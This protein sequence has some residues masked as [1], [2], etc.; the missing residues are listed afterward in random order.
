M[1][2]TTVGATRSNVDRAWLT[3][4]CESPRSSGVATVSAPSM[5]SGIKARAYTLGI[6]P[7]PWPS[8]RWIIRP[9]RKAAPSDRTTSPASL[10]RRAVQ[11]S[12]EVRP[13]TDSPIGK[14]AT[15]T[16]AARVVA[17]IDTPNSAPTTAATG[18]SPAARFHH[19]DRI[20]MRDMVSTEP[21]K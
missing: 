19:D 3:N 11:A 20:Q 5:A 14:A 6:T 4:R 2:P 10:R 17:E 8:A 1:I 7:R 16:A 9:A 21:L 12:G 18:S 15:P 13:R